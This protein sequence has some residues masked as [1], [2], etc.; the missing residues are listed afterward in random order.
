MHWRDHIHSDPNVLAGKPVVRGTRIPVD[1]ILEKLG[2]SETVEQILNAH[3]RL[4][5]A[6][7]QAALTF[8]AEALRA[9]TVYSVPD[10]AARS[11]SATRGS[12]VRSSRCCVAK[13]SKCCTLPR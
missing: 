13:D 10:E 3:P 4:T 8:A 1:L 7:L 2:A 11:S 6:G 5:R 12:T 9:D